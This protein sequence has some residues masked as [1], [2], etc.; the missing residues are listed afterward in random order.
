MESKEA[1]VLGLSKEERVPYGSSAR[2]LTFAMTFGLAA[3]AGCHKQPKPAPIVPPP[4]FPQSALSLPSVQ[5]LPPVGVTPVPPPPPDTQS[6]A[7]TRPPKP[8]PRH[9][10]EKKNSPEPTPPTSGS[11]GNANSA[12]SRS[13]P[14]PRITTPSNL[15]DT[16]GAISPTMAHSDEV[17]HRLT[18]AQL[19]QSTEDNLKNLVR[20][21][22]D[23]DK[24]VVEQIKNYLAQSRTATSE[25]DLVRAHNLALKAHLLSD[26]LVRR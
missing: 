1:Q 18:T 13:T 2:V 3:L 11:N 17:H 26:E 20:G 16:S 19:I 15:P 14:P 7:Q 10:V 6:K 5:P 4:T 25:N 12:V 8:R 21:L 23:D 9:P 24:A 22:S